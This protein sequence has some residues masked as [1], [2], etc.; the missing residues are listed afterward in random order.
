[1]MPAHP[2]GLITLLGSEP[3]AVA[4]TPP[5]PVLTTDDVGQPALPPVQ[6][7]TSS[8]TSSPSAGQ[9]AVAVSYLLSLLALIVAVPPAYISRF[10]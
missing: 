9:H 2:G 8:P 1:M 7:N 10:H 3:E 5:T 4:P 6:Q